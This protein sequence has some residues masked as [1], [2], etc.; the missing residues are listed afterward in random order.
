MATADELTGFVREA[1]VRGAPR[2]QI[3][4]VLLKTGWSRDQVHSALAGYADVDFPIPVPRPRAYLSAREAF[5]Y[6]LLFTT[7]YLSAYNL[8]VLVFERINRSFPDAAVT[9]Y[10][11][12]AQQAIRWALASLIVSFP[13][14]MYLSVV[15]ERSVRRDPSKRRSNVRRWL[16]YLTIFMAACILIGDFITLVYNALGGELTIRFVLKVIAIGI[17]AGTIFAYYLS[18]LRLEDTKPVVDDARWKRAVAGVALA[19]V[20]ATVVMG[21]MLTG[22]PAEE[23]TRRLDARRIDDLRAISDSVNAYMTRH[24]RLPSTLQELSA[25]PGLAMEARDPEGTAYEYR[26]TGKKGFELCATF[27]RDSTAQS[28]RASG[29]FWS[30]RAGRQCFPLEA[31]EPS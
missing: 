23:R 12:Y 13:V 25:E 7:L 3:E 31:K 15:V 2:A 9:D 27:G 6:L 8:G 16:M 20:G 19:A 28:R 26:V 18:D 1:L 17:I 30:H 22:P 14:F 29:G 11:D 5:M 10:G 24:K 4:E 21:L